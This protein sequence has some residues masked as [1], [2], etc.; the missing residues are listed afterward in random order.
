MVSGYTRGY[1]HTDSV[2]DRRVSDL[3]ENII[4]EQGIEVLLPEVKRR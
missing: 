4:K 1:L 2:K 3:N